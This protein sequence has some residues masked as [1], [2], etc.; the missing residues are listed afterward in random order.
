MMENLSEEERVNLEKDVMKATEEVIKEQCE[1]G[2]DEPTDGEVR[3]ENYIHYFCRFVEGIDFKTKT[4]IA[5]R[6]GAFTAQVPTIT[7][8]VSWRGSMSIAEEW[9]KS[10]AVSE[11]PVKYTLPGPMTIMGSTFDAFYKDEKALAMDLAKIVNQHVLELAEAGCKL[12]QVDEPLF[13][14]KPEQALAYGIAGLDKCFEGCPAGVEKQMHMRCG[15][16]GHVDQTDYL[17]ADTQAYVKIA[18]ALDDSCIDAVSIEDAWCRNDLS[19]LALFKKTKVIFGAMNVSS[20]RVETVPEM[21]SRLIEALKH[22]EPERLMVAPDCGLG[23]L[24]GKA[25]EEI[26]GR[27]LS[28]MCKA[29]RCVPCSRKRRTEREVDVAAAVAQPPQKK[30]A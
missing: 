4:E 18:P 20:S 13:A 7:G 17:K 10:Q 6:N 5:A 27:K 21:R 14:R 12:I 22:I 16:P 29:A 2:V 23:L 1:C 28:T 24:Q 8:K 3:R 25:Y 19:L 11:A 30:L 9:K 26:L 15:Y